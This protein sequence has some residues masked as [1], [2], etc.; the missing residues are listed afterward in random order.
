MLVAAA[1]AATGVLAFATGVEAR[2]YSFRCVVP[3]LL[4]QQV[5]ADISGDAPARVEAP[6]DL[7]NVSNFRGSVTVPPSAP[8]NIEVR[9]IVLQFPIPAGVEYVNGSI[10]ASGGGTGSVEGGAMVYRLAGPIVVSGGQTVTIGS[11]GAQFRA[12]GPIGTELGWR[13]G[14]VTAFIPLVS[15]TLTCTPPGGAAPFAVTG[16]GVD[17]TVFGEDTETVERRPRYRPRLVPGAGPAGAVPGDAQF[18]G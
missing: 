9:D 7:I 1:M 13:P 6:G 2:G 11:L 12:T 4:D 3:G 8:P 15:L 14:A 16:I 18:T 5:G 17:P 10:T